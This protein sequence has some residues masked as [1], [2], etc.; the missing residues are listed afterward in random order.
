MRNWK[1]LTLI[2]L[3][4]STGAFFVGRSASNRKDKITVERTADVAVSAPKRG[5]EV[6]NLAPN[7]N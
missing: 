7:F 5:T 3:T 2:L 6:G 4:I 1:L